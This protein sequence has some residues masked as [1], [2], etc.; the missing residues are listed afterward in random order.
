[1]K[2][3]VPILTHYPGKIVSFNP[4]KQTATV[5]IM[6]EQFNNKLYSMYTEYDFPV[7][8]DVVVQFPQGGDYFLTFP[9][10]VG[11]NCLLDFCDKGIDHWK[12][13]GAEKIGKFS[14]GVPKPDYFRAYNINDAVA[15]VGYNPI[16]QAI[17]NFHATGTELRNIERTQ[18]FTMLP[19][20]KMEIVTP[21]ELDITAPD[22]I[23]NG[24]TT[25]NGNLHVVG[26]IS[27]TDTITS[28][29]DVIATTVS[30]VNHLT[31]GVTPGPLSG[32]SNKPKA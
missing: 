25:M 27:C 7:L 30:L 22:T 26:K 8:Q 20:G 23:I 4:I 1:M 11:D 10:N 16:P 19:D 18:R 15:M 13:E 5:K 31:T 29:I 24:D 14:S 3:W 2:D 17:P 21:L 32:L 12:Y 9:V 28:D 6:R